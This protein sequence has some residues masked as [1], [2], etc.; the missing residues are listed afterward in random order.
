MSEKLSNWEIHFT[1]SEKIDC[2]DTL[3]VIENLEI[4]TS[5]GKTNQKSITGFNIKVENT[6]KEIAMEKASKKAQTFTDL[7]SATS[8]TASI[9]R[10]DGTS[11][12]KPTGGHTVSKT[13][14]ISYNIRNNAELNIPKQRLEDILENKD[15]ILSQ[16]LKYV[17]RATDSL[18]N[19]DPASTIKELVLACNE[20]PQGNSAKYKSLR[21]A[22]SHEIPKPETIQRIKNDF[23]QDYFVFTSEGRFDFSSGR[24]MKN[25]TL[26]ANSF[27]QQVRADI[28]K[29][30]LEVHIAIHAI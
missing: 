10:L 21:N 3:P 25:L 20:H 28:K 29:K 2:E 7:L 17:N 13:F 15:T 14:T 9:P 12:E 16:Q 1:L 18:K 6:T 8:G 5:I 30:D 23:G 24:N 11:V 26:E 19:R 22:L 4:E 27:L